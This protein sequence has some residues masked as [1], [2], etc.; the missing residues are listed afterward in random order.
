VQL[1]ILGGAGIGAFYAAA[2]LSGQASSQADAIVAPAVRPGRPA[3]IVTASGHADPAP[4]SAARVAAEVAL[5]SPA[6]RPAASAAGIPDRSDAIPG[7]TGQPFASLSWVV[8][9]PPPKPL[10]VVA[11]PPAPPV[12]P[13]LPFTFVGLVEKGTPKPQAFLSRGD[14]LLVVAAGDL[15]DGGNYRIEA[16]DA[17]QIVFIHLPTKTK[18]V[19][20]LSGGSQ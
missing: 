4:A 7:D 20:N 19:I 10:V 16:V 9:P 13:P 1:L 2:H 18:Q 3:A 5:T 17:S 6:Q 15:L 11:A 8:A 14:E 12:A